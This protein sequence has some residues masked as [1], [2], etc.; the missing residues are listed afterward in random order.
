MSHYI[1][2]SYTLRKL[3]IQLGGSPHETSEAEYNV[4]N[5]SAR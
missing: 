4:F 3:M 1:S 2:Y 5:S